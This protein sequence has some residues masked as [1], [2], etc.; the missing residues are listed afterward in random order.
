MEPLKDTV[1]KDEMEQIRDAWQAYKSF[2]AARSLFF[3]LIFL[4]LV[5]VQAGFWAIDL[6][7]A[8]TPAEIKAQ[9]IS[10]LWI[11]S[12]QAHWE[13]KKMAAAERLPL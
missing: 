10:G 5:L 4:G 13:R 12:L 3:L 7:W 11:L 8:G 1:E 6:G 9:G 2:R